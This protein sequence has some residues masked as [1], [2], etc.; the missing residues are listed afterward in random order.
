VAEQVEHALQVDAVLG[1]LPA[2]ASAAELLAIFE[3]CFTALLRRAQQTLGEVTV[4][5][6]ADRVL[7]DVATRFPLLQAL[8]SETGKGVHFG[9]LRQRVHQQDNDQIR[10]GMRA[11]LIEFLTVIGHLTADIFTPALHLELQKVRLEPPP[12]TAGRVPQDDTARSRERQ[13]MER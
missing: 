13:G 2:G 4:A 7:H 3:G 9:R 11:T 10:Q 5:A 8:S 12:G 6:I 1:R